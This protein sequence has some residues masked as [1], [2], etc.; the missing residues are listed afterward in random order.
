MEKIY[1]YHSDMARIDNC[2]QMIVE[3]NKYSG[4]SSLRSCCIYSCRSWERSLCDVII[5]VGMKS[6]SSRRYRPSD[7]TDVESET[8]I[9]NVSPSVGLF[10][11]G[12]VNCS[13]HRLPGNTHDQT[14]HGHPSATY[15][16]SKTT[17]CIQNSWRRLRLLPGPASEEV[18]SARW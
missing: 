12:G 5:L 18:A 13:T 8:T 15:P 1:G 10:A 3:K 6:D 9:R 16:D 11:S 4:A 14:H 7:R 2:Y 17:V